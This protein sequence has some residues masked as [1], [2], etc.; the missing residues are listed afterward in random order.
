MMRGNVIV[1]VIIKAMELYVHVKFHSSVMSEH[2]NFLLQYGLTWLNRTLAMVARM[3]LY[4]LYGD[5]P[6]PEIPVSEYRRLQSAGL[7]ERGEMIDVFSP[8]RGVVREMEIT[9]AGK[10]AYIDVL[11]RHHNYF[12]RK[13]ASGA[14]H[15]AKPRATL[16]KEAGTTMPELKRLM[17][18]AASTMQLYVNNA[19]KAL[20]DS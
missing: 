14:F 9:E 1:E 7:H 3:I 20:G 13:L 12:L 10:L 15:L 18:I 19:S 8:P 11:S 2:V 6:R 16:A 5:E 17:K 4:L